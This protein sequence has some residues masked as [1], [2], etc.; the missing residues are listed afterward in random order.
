MAIIRRRY[1]RT[2]RLDSSTD[3]EVHDAVLSAKRTYLPE[4]TD[5]NP[6]S[7]ISRFIDLLTYVIAWLLER[8]NAVG[9][10][11]LIRTA[12]RYDSLRNLAALVGYIP[13]QRTPSTVTLQLSL[14]AA[15][16]D[17]VLAAETYSFQ[18]PATPAEPEP[19]MFELA[20]DVTI[21]AGVTDITFETIQGETVRNEILGTS[22][23]TA[24][25]QYRTLY[26]SVITASM[27]LEVEEAS[28]ASMIW[29]EW[30]EVMDWLNSQAS[31]EHYRVD[32][33]DLGRLEVYFGDG[34]RGKIPP[35]GS[36]IRLTYRV[37]RNAR[38]GNVPAG[39]VTRMSPTI[40]GCTLPNPSAA[41]GWADRET[42]DDIRVNAP[43]YARVTDRII[44]LEDYAIKPRLALASVGRVIAERRGW[45][46]N[47][48]LLRILDTDGDAASAA[49]MAE[50]E[51]YVDDLNPATETVVALPVQFE[52]VTLI[53]SVTL[54]S[55]YDWATVKAAIEEA[56]DEWFDPLNRDTA[57]NYTIEPG[58]TIYPGDIRRIV[59]AID[60]VRS[61][62][63]TPDSNI[64]IAAGYLPRL[65]DDTDIRRVA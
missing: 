38:N 9:N 40:V 8:L 48:V 54:R 47:T 21:P 58:M 1:L 22:D 45:G 15:A 53:I 6:A 17:R 65:S 56:L 44:T 59:E 10:E 41:T 27:I 28:G 62:E 25:Q 5:E 42:L 3:E 51:A 23:G 32:W 19:L 64:S 30:L 49:L 43:D 14:P 36:R 35:A 37:L 20:E 34:S 61:I 18:V 57:G 4:L 11:L 52:G 50:V 24:G 60:G 63:L 33:D 26:G 2:V 7:V 16:S 13:R 31:S 29:V 46:E 39:S 12:S 55:G